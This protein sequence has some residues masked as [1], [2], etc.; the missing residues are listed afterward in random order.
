MP[1]KENKK[2]RKGARG[3]KLPDPIPKGEILTDLTKQSWILGDPIGVGGF[4]ALYTAVASSKQSNDYDHVIKIE[5]HQN[6]PLFVEMHFYMRNASSD[7]I[8][9]WKNK[10]KLSHLGVPKFI[11]NGSHE[12]LG[13][14]YRFLVMERFGKDLWK[15][16]LENGRQFPEVTVYRVAIQII[17]ALEYIHS[18]SYTHGDIKGANLLLDKNN[19]KNVFLVDYGLAAKVSQTKEYKPDPKRAHN[20]TIE[21]TSRDAHIGIPTKRGDVEILGYNLVQWLSGE[22]P[23]EKELKDPKSVHNAKLK[24]LSDVD[25]FLKDCFIKVP[26]A[27]RQYM[28]LLNEMEFNDTPNY[29]EMRS[30][31]EKA[32]QRRRQQVYGELVFPS[33][34]ASASSTATPESKAKKKK[35]E[36]G[37]VLRRRP[38]ACEKIDLS[39]SDDSEKI[40]NGIV[41][42]EKR[43]KLKNL[44]EIVDNIDDDSETEY[45]I[46]VLKK[47]TRQN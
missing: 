12:R 30:I 20:G 15:L 3:Y 41:I 5:P 47:K 36:P 21:Y 17:D 37:R 39:P 31:F 33:T 7:E 10:K 25:V 23:W 46:K 24:A 45:D 26:S 34:G 8:E 27:I 22:L 6:G 29:A 42:D 43:I 44:K 1:P 11:S 2:V 40:T 14:K 9:K 4:G 32:L 16:F 35:V 13:V 38:A 28:H 18:K 19:S